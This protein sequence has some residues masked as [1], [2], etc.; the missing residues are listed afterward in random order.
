MARVVGAG[1]WKQEYD[2]AGPTQEYDAAGPTLDA[3]RVRVDRLVES[4]AVMKHFWRDDGELRR[5]GS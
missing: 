5:A 2:A 3:P 1:W 4:V